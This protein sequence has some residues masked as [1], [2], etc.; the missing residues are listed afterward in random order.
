MARLEQGIFDKGQAG[1][2]GVVYAQAGLGNDFEAT[3]GQQGAEFLE[4][5]RVAAGQDDA[6]LIHGL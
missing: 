3:V 2:L 6:L 4:L 5:A 1:F